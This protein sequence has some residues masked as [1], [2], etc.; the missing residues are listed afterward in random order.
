M[1]PSSYNKD[2][3]CPNFWQMIW[4]TKSKIIVMLCKLEIDFSGCS[5][6]FPKRRDQIVQHGNFVIKNVSKVDKNV[7][8]K[9]QKSMC[10]YRSFEV[11]KISAT[12]G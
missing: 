8:K 6:Y 10:Y 3:S 9:N 1:H 12:G 5:E 7:F 4:E 11:S 2:N